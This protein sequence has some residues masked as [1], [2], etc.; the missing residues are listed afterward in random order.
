MELEQRKNTTGASAA[1]AATAV[2]GGCA[3]PV[4]ATGVI[5]TL[6]FGTS[7]IVAGS[8]GAG[9]MATYAGLVPAGSL[10]AFLQSAGAVGLGAGPIGVLVISGA[11]LAGLS[12]YGIYKLV[13]RRATQ[14][15][16]VGS[17]V[18][19]SKQSS[20]VFP[21]DCR[22]RSLSERQVLDELESARQKFG[23]VVGHNDDLQ[24]STSKTRTVR[25]TCITSPVDAS[26]V[27]RKSVLQP[28]DSVKSHST[29]A[30]REH[31]AR[32]PVAPEFVND[33]TGGG[34]ERVSCHLCTATFKSK[35]ACKQHTYAKHG[36]F[37]KGHLP[38]PPLGLDGSWV[39]REEFSGVKSFGFFECPGPKCRHFWIS[40][41]ASKK[42][43]QGCRQCET[44]SRPKFMWVNK[45]PRNPGMKKK[46][47]PHDSSRCDA[48]EA[49][50]CSWSSHPETE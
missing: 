41:H 45:S 31:A 48:C 3:A 30:S 15:D 39:E 9:F 26:S 49:G 22:R 40:A 33:S 37:N 47:A 12:G 35:K 8:W 16:H 19:T 43:C 17:E 36:R 50:D 21:V 34:H 6:G 7:G 32:E 46:K 23:V 24:R 10:C 5:S 27:P 44:K 28:V 42:Y 1:I 2:V 13:Q 18:R 38:P 29:T 14:K 4:V 20:L 11:A 25:H